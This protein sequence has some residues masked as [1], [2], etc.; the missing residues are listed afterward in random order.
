MKHIIAT[1][2]IFLFIFVLKQSFVFADELTEEM[3]KDGWISIFDGK[4]LEGWKSNEKYEGFEV[5]NG[6]I[7]GKGERNHLYYIKEEFTN[8][9][10]KMDVKINHQGNSGVYIKSQ[11]EEGVFPTTGFELQVNATHS[12][13]LKTGTLYDCLKYLKSPHGDDEWFE[14]HVICN[15]NTVEVKVNNEIL[16]IYIDRKEPLP[17]NTKITAANKRIAQKGYL[18][19]QQHDPKSVPEFKNIYIKKLGL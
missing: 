19:L 10:L 2:F 8:F 15:K 16:Y 3:Q 7:V 13:P 12:N 1:I 9:E 17:E 4:T 18:V 14:Y 11:W 5:K 6:C